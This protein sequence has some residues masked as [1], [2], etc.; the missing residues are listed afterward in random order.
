MI[1]LCFIATI[2]YSQKIVIPDSLQ[3]KTFDEIEGLIR[4]HVRDSIIASS[5]SNILLARG[6]QEK[7]SLGLTMGYFQVSYDHF[8]DLPKRLAY[9]D[10]SIA[11]SNGLSHP[12]YPLANYIGRASVRK[13]LGSYILALEDYLTALNI[14]EKIKNDAFNDIKHNIGNLKLEFGEYE[15]AKKMY[16][17]IITY[18]NKNGIKG[19]GHLG[20]ILGLANSYRKLNQKDSAT[21]YTQ[22]GLEKS[23]KDSLNIYYQFL[24]NAGINLYNDKKYQ[25]SLYSISKAIPFIEKY[26]GH[27]TAFLIDAYLH[28]GK[29]YQALEKPK[30]ALNSLEKID[31]YFENEKSRTEEMREGYE[32]LINHYKSIDDKN[33]QLYYINRVFAVDSALNTNYR[34]LHKTITNKY[35]TPQLLEEKQRLINNLQKKEKIISLK[36]SVTLLVVI[37]LSIFFLSVY[38]RKVQYKKRYRAIMYPKN[39]PE[40]KSAEPLVAHQKNNETDAKTIDIPENIVQE[41]L[42]RIT[43][44][45]EKNG[46]L[47]RNLTISSLAKKLHTNSKYLSKII[48][49]YKQKRFSVYINELRVDYVIEQLKENPKFRLYSI[50]G[51]ARELGYN[52]DRAFSK[53]FYQKTGVYPSYFIKQLEKEKNT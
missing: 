18:E 27:E 6:K 19:E 51:I 53:A 12:I 42:E 32:L 29:V 45:E 44:F 23:S 37:I 46:F 35:D 26:D 25:S 39:E 1:L 3:S 22:I 21:Y 16:K 50:K 11:V 31:W 14:A 48:N 38:Y 17:E 33:K 36:Y 8:N 20:T 5:L 24:L 40:I 13:Q 4:K 34:N 7:D 49:H 28:L 2:G 41:I 30:M 10:S 43:Q 9:L 47:A 15:D 52:N